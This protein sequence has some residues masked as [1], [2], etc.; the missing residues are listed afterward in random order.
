[1]SDFLSLLVIFRLRQSADELI[2]FLFSLCQA[3]LTGGFKCNNRSRPD[4][5]KGM[6]GG[7]P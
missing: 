3:E 7:T 4:R 5:R 1:M 6:S 2:S